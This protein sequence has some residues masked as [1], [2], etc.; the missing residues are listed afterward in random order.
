MICEQK[1][2]Q[3]EFCFKEASIEG[4]QKEI[5]SLKEILKL[6]S[7]VSQNSD[8]PTKTVKENSDIFG[9]VFAFFYQQFDKVFYIPIGFLPVLSKIFERIMFY[10]CLLF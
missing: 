10:K 6:N 8:I 7:K 9:K 4:T 1:K 2:V 3:I 5:L